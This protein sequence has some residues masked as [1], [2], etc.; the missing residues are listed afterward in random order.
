MDVISSAAAVT[1]VIGQT[2]SLIQQ[3][4]QASEAVRAAPK[5]IR[6]TK[7]QL[8]NLIDTA[9]E[10]MHEPGL[11]V[12][13]I[14][15]QLNVIYGITTEL[16]QI[17]KSMEELQRKSKMYQGM[18]AL[19]K[20]QRDDGR[21]DDVLSRLES[22]KT[23]LAIRIDVAHVK[24][25]QVVSI[26][27]QRIE[28]NVQTAIQ[29]GSDRPE[30]QYGFRIEENRA[31]DGSEQLNGIIGMGNLKVST[32]ASIYQNASEGHSKQRNIILG[33][34]SLFKLFQTMDR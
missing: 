2:L 24:M 34:P 19:V 32:T 6:D 31:R 21:L 22:A 17:L 20:K 3:L 23:E 14:N 1:Q 13:T 28:H 25:T 18:R 29:R 15:A 8:S 11:Q 30:H 5:A 27:V 12:P 16:N 9:H 10:V 4:Y 33:D 26:G 7:S